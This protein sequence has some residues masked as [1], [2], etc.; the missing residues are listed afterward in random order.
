MTLLTRLHNYDQQLFAKVFK[1]RDHGIVIPLARA[2]SRSGEGVL[3]VLIPVL[4]WQL[5]LPQ[6]SALLALTALAF[7]LER[8]L[9]WALKNSLKR[10][11]PQ[12][13][14]PGLRSLGHTSNQFSFPSGHSSRAFLLATVMVIVYGAP[15]LVLY[16]WACSVAM[17]RVVLGVHY[18]GDILA[19]ALVGSGVA[20]F[21]AKLLGLI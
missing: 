1:Q 16:V 7:A 17:A 3:H 13:T 8:A 21:S 14:I 12:N 6:L 2:L 19:G 15:A 9:H 18:P 20:V 10:P 5:N 11:R 4:V